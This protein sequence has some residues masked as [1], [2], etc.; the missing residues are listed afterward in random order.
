MACNLVNNFEVVL[1]KKLWLCSVLSRT[2]RVV[3]PAPTP[4]LGEG[5]GEGEGEGKGEGEGEG[6]G[7]GTATRRL[8]RG[9]C[10]IS[11]DLTRIA[12]YNI[13]V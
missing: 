8:P 12:L 4:H 5:T 6:E 7:E 3:V 11:I 9:P 2:L 13:C 10:D 1:I